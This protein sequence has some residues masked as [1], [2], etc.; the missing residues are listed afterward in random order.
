MPYCEVSVELACIVILLF[1]NNAPHDNRYYNPL[2]YETIST[3][4]LL[5]KS[6]SADTVATS[7]CLTNAIGDRQGRAADPSHQTRSLI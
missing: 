3:S 7:I 2:N 6:I 1:P 5:T 4:R